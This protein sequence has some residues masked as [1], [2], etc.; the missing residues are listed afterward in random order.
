MPPVSLLDTAR[1][2]EPLRV[3]EMRL[4]IALMMGMMAGVAEGLLDTVEAGEPL[5]ECGH[6]GSQ[7]ISPGDGN[8]GRCGSCDKC[9]YD[10][11]FPVQ[12]Y[13]VLPHEMD[14]I[15]SFLSAEKK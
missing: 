2:L 15:R 7:H 9:E 1:R 10:E 11:Q 5:C 13:L 4:A 8:R 6:L 12:A 14:E 3:A